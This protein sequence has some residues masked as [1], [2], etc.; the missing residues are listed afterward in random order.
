MVVNVHNLAKVSILAE[1]RWINNFRGLPD[2]RPHH[3]S[4]FTGRYVFLESVDEV[5]M[6]HRLVLSLRRNRQFEIRNEGCS[7]KR[8][9]ILGVV[10]KSVDLELEVVSQPNNRTHLSFGFQG[11][12]S[13]REFEFELESLV[14][15]KDV[16]L[17]KAL[18]WITGEHA[19]NLSLRI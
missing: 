8:I 14:S 17:V 6:D 4:S 5:S 15:V 1:S 19:A 18:G 7:I 11:T 13:G 9:R 2:N 3:E 16:F 12:N 10:A